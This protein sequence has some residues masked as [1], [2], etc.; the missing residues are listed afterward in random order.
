MHQDCNLYSINSNL[1][2]KYTKYPKLIFF[3]HIKNPLLLFFVIYMTFLMIYRNC[4]EQ[5]KNM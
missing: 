3:L 2:Y 5:N 4:N 1:H